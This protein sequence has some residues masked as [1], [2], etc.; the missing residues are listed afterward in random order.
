MKKCPYCAESIQDEA[1]VCR[2]CGKDLNKPAPTAKDPA[3]QKAWT[4]LGGIGLG[5]YVVILF[6]NLLGFFSEMPLDVYVTAGWIQSLALVAFLL[7]L[8]GRIFLSNKS[9]TTSK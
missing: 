3:K 4:I 5:L 7:G 6:L 9:S 2:Y 1:L 8:V